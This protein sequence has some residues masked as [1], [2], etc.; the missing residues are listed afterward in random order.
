M[1]LSDNVLII[2][3]PANCLFLK[4]VVEKSNFSYYHFIIKHFQNSTI[5]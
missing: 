1:K 2:L 4:V 5:Q 3:L